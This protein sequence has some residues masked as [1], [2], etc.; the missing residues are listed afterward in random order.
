MNVEPAFSLSQP[1]F[2]SATFLPF[3][4]LI[5]AY[6]KLFPLHPQHFGMGDGLLSQGPTEPWIAWRTPQSSKACP[7]L[8]RTQ[9]C[10]IRRM[11]SRWLRAVANH[12]APTSSRG[13]GSASGLLEQPVSR[14]KPIWHSSTPTPVLVTFWNRAAP[15]PLHPPRSVVAGDELSLAGEESRAQSALARRSRCRPRDRHALM[16][17]SVARATGR[18]SA[19]LDCS[20]DRHRRSGIFVGS[21]AS[22][23]FWPTTGALRAGPR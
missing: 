19:Y 9:S 16:F 5:A 17:N 13:R 4:Y 21:T 8:P 18:S 22:I 1:S 11:P 3:F 10:L 12:G 2:G 20:H 7:D 14:Q 6:S 15:P 23:E